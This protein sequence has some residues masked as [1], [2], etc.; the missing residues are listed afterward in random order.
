MSG[1]DRPQVLSTYEADELVRE[2]AA[3][4]S[5]YEPGPF[6]D[7]D[8]KEQIEGIESALEGIGSIRTR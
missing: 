2:A 7:R 4:A 3:C 8:L 5:S 6:S 1:Y